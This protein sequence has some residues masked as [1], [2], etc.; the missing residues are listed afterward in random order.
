MSILQN[1]EE[2]LVFRSSKALD[3]EHQVE[4]RDAVVTNLLKKCQD[5]EIGLK[6]QKMWK[7][8]C[9]HKEEHEQR[10]ERLQMWDEYVDDIDLHY[11]GE[12]QVHIPISM[13][14]LKT[15][16]A[17]MFQALTAVDPPFSVRAMQ[18]VY[19]EDVDM[20]FGLMR[21]TLAEWCNYNEGVEHVIDRWLWNWAGWGNGIL[22]LKW[23][24]KFSRYID[25][26]DTYTAGPSQW[27]VIINPDSGTIEEV[28][29]PAIIK[30][31]IEEPVTEK[32]FEGPVLEYI[33]REDIAIIGGSDIQR[34]DAVIHR[35]WFTLDKLFSCAL[36]K[37]FDMEVVKEVIS[38]GPD[39]EA[40]REGMNIKQD[41][42]THSGIQTLDVEEDHSRYEI[43]EAHLEVDINDDGLNEAIIVW[44]DAETGKELRA[45]YAHRVNKGGKRPFVNIE[46]IPR[47]GHGYAMGLLEL[48]HP[49]SVEMDFIHNIKIDIGL[50]SA[51][52][53]GFYRA[54][55]G[56]D[57]VKLRIR[58]G[59][60]IPVDDPSNHVNFPNLGDRSGF[61]KEEEMFIMQ[62]VERLTAINDINTATL[63]RQGAARTATGVNTLVSENSANL[64]I[65][66]KRMQRGWRQVL[67]LLWGMLQ[68][69]LPDGTEFRVTGEDGREYFK[70]V[71]R[72]DIRSRVD[73]IIEATS[74][75][76]NKQ[77]MLE[78]S[79]Q[80][81]AQCINPFFFQI[82]IIEPDGVFEALK[83][84]FLAL[85]RKDYSRFIK[86]TNIKSVR[87]LTAEEELR[88]LLAG[89]QVPVTPEM[90][91]QGFIQI[92]DAMK[93]TDGIDS[94]FGQA[95]VKTVNA[96]YEQHKSMLKN[97]QAQA[98]QVQQA[99]Q[100]M[101]N[102][103]GA[104]G[105]AAPGAEPMLPNNGMNAFNDFQV[106][107]S[108]LNQQVQAGGGQVPGMPQKKGG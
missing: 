29:S 38:G 89:K 33:C 2:Q 4:L 40:G 6:I 19:Q 106:G 96:Q 100:Q 34:C 24:R 90:D 22:K 49:L 31:Q 88:R 36:Q 47:E 28:E 1:D 18:E 75:N 42:E 59:D 21:W 105:A 26:K 61:F 51:Q 84:Y 79:Q 3:K 77:I 32:I 70:K 63:G 102:K 54:A 74:A 16:H 82:G 65:F 94:M 12:S 98:G 86:K 60:L 53:F 85:G 14:V 25:V 81:L 103:M 71:D 58:P 37:I 76:S 66:I 44:V 48:L 64:D 73:F 107:R 27:Q 9:S 87:I 67:R 5:K 91:H 68:Q 108:N 23:D 95:N 39:A 17:R 92:W 35:E 15:F 52:P 7:S 83:D 46:F 78:Q 72:H 104:G 43:L 99:N 62:Y 93:D 41:R 56:M 55:T 30:S 45:T 50:L 8:H 11:D 97:M 20:V 13:I 10:M 57:P 101:F 80:I 69:R